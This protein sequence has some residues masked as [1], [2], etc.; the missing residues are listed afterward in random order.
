MDFNSL[1]FLFFISCASVIFFAVPKKFQWLVLLLSSTYFYLS[2]RTPHAWVLLFITLVTYLVGLGI[3]KSVHQKKYVLILG[4]ILNFGALFIFKYLDFFNGSVNYLLGLLDINQQLPLYNLKL[5][6][7]ISFYIF[8]AVGYLIDVF[9]GTVKAEKHLGIFA[10]FMSFFPKLVAGPIERS[11]HVL[12]QLHTPSTKNN[13]NIVSGIQLFTFGLFKKVVVAD[14]LALVVDRVFLA[15]PE[16][17][18]LSL[19]LT[20]IFF[21]WQIYADF[22]G[23]TDMARGAARLFGI[24][25]LENFKN[26]YTATSVSDFW[27]RWHI[28]L[29]SWLR[30]YLY[31]PL[32]G[33]REGRFR[34]YF[35]FLIVFTLCGV[36]HGAAWTFV[37]WGLFHGIV[38]AIEKAVASLNKGK[39]IIPKVAGII[40]TYGMVCLSWVLFRAATLSDAQYIFRNSAI[41]VKNFIDPSYIA[42]T[43]SKVF[44]TN[45]LEML[46]ALFALF[47]IVVI[48][49]VSSKISIAKLIHK[50]HILLRFALYIT[51][52]VLIVG[53]RNA[54]LT[55]FIYVQF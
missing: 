30:D 20:I 50:Q 15:L 29:S 14:N 42:A 21:S 35:N 1:S 40:Y 22:S 4:L 2:W 13:D 48:E 54:D 34:T 12:P 33:S 11:S 49:Y 10:T 6:L 51:V 52:V 9:R 36:W 28:S 5:P 24:N 17:K 7:G 8:L 41:G 39:I 18:G 47:S 43:F 32:G 23:Y 45:T 55:E 25:L 46:I 44:D 38:L 26:P 19:I 16:H 53:L 27:R 3:D 31:I 37:L